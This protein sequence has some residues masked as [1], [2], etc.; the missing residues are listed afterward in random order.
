MARLPPGAPADG[1]GRRARRAR[2][3]G[4]QPHG[5]E[6]REPHYTA[7]LLEID[8]TAPS[9]DSRDM[10][11]ARPRWNISIASSRSPDLSRRMPAHVELARR[12]EARPS[13]GSPS[14]CRAAR[15]E[16][17]PSPTWSAWRGSR[18]EK[19]A[20]RGSVPPGLPARS[21][22][23]EDLSRAGLPGHIDSARRPISG[24]L[25]PDPLPRVR[26]AVLTALRGV[27]SPAG[28]SSRRPAGPGR[29]ER[30]ISPSARGPARS[31]ADLDVGTGRPPRSQSPAG[32]LA[33]SSWPTGL[34]DDPPRRRP[35]ADRG[36]ELAA[37]AYEEPPA[38]GPRGSAC[39][40]STPGGRPSTG[41]RAHE[42][43]F[44]RLVAALE[45]HEPVVRLQA[46]RSLDRLGDPRPCRPWRSWSIRPKWSTRRHSTRRS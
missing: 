4:R 15:P 41:P 14:A 16:T 20:G 2:L 18:R 5:D 6:R 31:P 12:G 36:L 9:P 46:L 33:A 37:S 38:E 19:A 10:S 32:R 45:D 23:G 1:R 43:A 44:R 40:R 7:D 11:R 26:R 27:D 29:I 30:P 21:Q 42:A 3:C 34:P 8:A 13:R 24:T 22:P 39:S 35:A 25:H 17:P 28:R